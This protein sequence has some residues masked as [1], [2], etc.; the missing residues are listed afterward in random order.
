MDQPTLNTS[1]KFWNHPATRWVAVI[2]GALIAAVLVAFG[3]SLVAK[4]MMASGQGTWF[5]LEVRNDDPTAEINYGLGFHLM[6]YVL[7]PGLAAGSFVYVGRL[8]APTQKR[9]VGILLA[10]VTVFVAIWSYSLPVD[11]IYGYRGF[12]NWIALF[13]FP[14]GGVVGAFAKIE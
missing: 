6:K 14:V 13:A 8:I 7:R 11:E 1:D 2:P 3:T 4:I 5:G 10:S 12:W 9:V